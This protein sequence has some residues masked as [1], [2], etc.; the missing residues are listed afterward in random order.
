MG[1]KHYRPSFVIALLGQCNPEEREK[2]QK[3]SLDGISRGSGTARTS[4]KETGIGSGGT[5]YASSARETGCA[6]ASGT[7][8]NVG[9]LAGAK[10]AAQENTITKGLNNLENSE[11]H[12]YV[13]VAPPVPD[14]EPGPVMLNWLDW[15]KIPPESLGSSGLVT[16]SIR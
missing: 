13:P 15:A 14:D 16:K 5:R 10:K 6:S 11:K 4:R 2:D 3:A 8:L 9:C 12:T 1:I 7:I